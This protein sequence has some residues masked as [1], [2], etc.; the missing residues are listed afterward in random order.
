M[1][2]HLVAQN[3]VGDLGSMNEVELRKTSLQ[4][5]LLW[6]VIFEGVK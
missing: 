2:E 3:G 6:L 5:A 1:G 4:V